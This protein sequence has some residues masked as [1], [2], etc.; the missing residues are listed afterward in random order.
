MVAHIDAVRLPRRRIAPHRHA[1]PLGYQNQDQRR[2]ARTSLPASSLSCGS[3]SSDLP[4]PS[5]AATRRPAAGITA[6]SI[7]TNSN[8]WSTATDRAIAPSRRTNQS[9][10]RGSLGPRML[11]GLQHQARASQART[12]PTRVER[13]ARMTDSQGPVW[14]VFERPAHGHPVRAAGSVHAVDAE[15]ALQNAWAVSRPASDRRAAG[16]SPQPGGDQ[17]QGR[18][19]ERRARSRQRWGT[20]EKYCVFCRCGT[21]IAYEEASSVHAASPEQAA[22]ARALE[23]KSGASRPTTFVTQ[24]GSF[25]LRPSF[26]ASRPRPSAHSCQPHKWFRD[27]K[28]FPRAA[29]MREIEKEASNANA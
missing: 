27:H 2:A 19:W 14:Q 6:R 23:Q 10:R 20:E 3:W 7:S 26:R 1:P 17:E 5:C 25:R 16:R 8:E 9:T 21:K 28:S 13:S 11:L 22:L 29:L 18:L 15:T 24:S 12:D 4:I